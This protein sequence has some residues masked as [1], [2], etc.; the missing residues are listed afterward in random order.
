MWFGLC[1]VEMQGVR[2]DTNSGSARKLH[3]GTLVF[4]LL[5]LSVWGAAFS[6]RF[7]LFFIEGLGILG[8]CNLF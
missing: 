5:E 2:L 6:L 7:G 4:A 3:C 8:N 1:P